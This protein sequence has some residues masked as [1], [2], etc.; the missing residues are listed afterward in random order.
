VRLIQRSG[1]S[2]RKMAPELGIGALRRWIEQAEVEA[3]RARRALK[4]TEREELV[5]VGRENQRL[6]RNPKKATVFCAKGT[7]LVDQ[8]REIAGKSG[9]NSKFVHSP[10]L[11]GLH[12]PVLMRQFSA[13][14]ARDAQTPDWLLERTGFEPPSPVN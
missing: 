4:H 12:K 6:E 7:R 10:V 1:K 13:T 11:F 9:C 3:A 8:Q 14:V 2:I 5:E